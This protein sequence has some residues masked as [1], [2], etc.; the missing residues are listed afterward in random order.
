MTSIM[1]LEVKSNSY[2]EVLQ[3]ILTFK[4]FVYKLRRRIEPL[5]AVTALRKALMQSPSSPK[6]KEV[7]APMFALYDANAATNRQTGGVRFL[8]FN[9]RAGS[10]L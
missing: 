5:W 9:G 2:S 4:D 6:A 8:N 1:N 3:T 7:A 10:K